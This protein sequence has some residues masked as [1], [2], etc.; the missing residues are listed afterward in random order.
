MNE[1]VG[2]LYRLG[3]IT[4]AQRAD[5]LA[6]GK[7]AHRLMRNLARVSP[8]A[9]RDMRKL[10]GVEL[11]AAVRKLARGEDGLAN[12]NDVGADLPAGADRGNLVRLFAEPA[13]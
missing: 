5:P 9:M 3:L 8:E 10:R 11:G 12:A 2:L 1:L 13:D 7:A 4:Y 6:V